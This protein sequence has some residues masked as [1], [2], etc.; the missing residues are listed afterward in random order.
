MLCGIVGQAQTGA[1]NSF[2]LLLATDIAFLV[3]ERQG[4]L[5]AFFDHYLSNGLR[6]NAI[7]L[8]LLRRDLF[9]RDALI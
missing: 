1:L 7:A 8:A 4:V 5:L 6:R 9:K 2:S 3:P